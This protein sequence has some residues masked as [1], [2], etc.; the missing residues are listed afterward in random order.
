MELDQKAKDLKLEEEKE[1]VNGSLQTRLFPQLFSFFFWVRILHRIDFMLCA[2]LDHKDQTFLGDEKIQY[3]QKLQ[4]AL[5]HNGSMD[6]RNT[7][8]K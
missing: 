5:F 4:R 1:N 7:V 8:T 3:I 6:F 2:S